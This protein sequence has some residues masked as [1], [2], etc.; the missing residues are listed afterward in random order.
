MS[1]Y[2]ADGGRLVASAEP[3]RAVRLG[4]ATGGPDRDRE[5]LHLLLGWEEMGLLTKRWK[6]PGPT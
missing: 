4:A 6:T 5:T 3:E 1:G 2:T